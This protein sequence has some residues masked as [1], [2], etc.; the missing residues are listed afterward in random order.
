MI[1]LSHHGHSYGVC[2]PIRTFGVRFLWAHD[3]TDPLFYL[4]ITYSS[5]NRDS[6]TSIRS[7]AHY[8]DVCVKGFF[9]C[10][11]VLCSIFLQISWAVRWK[12]GFKDVNTD[13]NWKL[14]WKGMHICVNTYKSPFPRLPPLSLRALVNFLFLPVTF[15]VVPIPFFNDLSW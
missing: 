8:V 1:Y 5:C 3:H 10:L 2:A 7:Y 6:S 9:V 12:W 13:S 4:C 11:W 14:Y 15:I